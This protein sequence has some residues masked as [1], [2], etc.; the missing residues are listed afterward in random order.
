MRK[1]VVRSPAGK[2][3]FAPYSSASGPP[4]AKRA[5]GADAAADPETMLSRVPL[6]A[7]AT[8]PA[9][10]AASRHAAVSGF[11]VAGSVALWEFQRW[12][13]RAR[14]SANSWASSAGGTGG[15]R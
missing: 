12:L 7:G 1:K 3:S 10:P 4:G 14:K 9:R 5:A 11:I 8:H 6:G 15:R 2:P 13:D